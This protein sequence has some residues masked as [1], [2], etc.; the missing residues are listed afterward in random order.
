MRLLLQ[1]LTASQ[2]SSVQVFPSL[3][4]STVPPARQTA[5]R[6]VRGP[7]QDSP[8]QEAARQGVPS[9]ASDHWV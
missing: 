7:T 1:P 5:P 4:S 9:V 3:Q 2:A 6:Q 8:E